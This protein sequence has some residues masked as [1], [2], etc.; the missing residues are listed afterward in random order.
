[1]RSS[2]AARLYW[3]GL[4]PASVLSFV[5][6]DMS[7]VMFRRYRGTCYSWTRSTALDVSLPC[8]AR[9][10][11]LCGPRRRVDSG[12]PVDMTR[13]TRRAAR[14][15]GGVQCGVAGGD[16]EALLALLDRTSYVA[17]PMREPRPQDFAGPRGVATGSAVPGLCSEQRCLSPD[18]GAATRSSRCAHRD[19]PADH[20]ITRAA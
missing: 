12:A 9:L 7:A 6:H 11:S 3:D 5:L 16:F 1:M 14:V 10:A 4:S 20:V 8:D 17:G 19:A 18:C 13:S 2:V 15:A